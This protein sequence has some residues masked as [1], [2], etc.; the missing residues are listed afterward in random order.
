MAARAVIF[1]HIAERETLYDANQ[2]D[3]FDRRRRAFFKACL[4]CP[5]VG[6]VFVYSS[7]G[8][9]Y[10]VKA[11]VNDPSPS[12]PLYVLDGEQRIYDAL[13]IVIDR[14]AE[15][16]SPG[17]AES[18][19]STGPKFV[20]IG[21]RELASHL[22]R[23]QRV[24]PELVRS[25]ATRDGTFT[26]DSPKYVEAI[27]RLVRPNDPVVRVDIDVEVNPA[28]IQRILDEAE[29][30]A[31]N[32]PSSYWWFSGCY[33][34]SQSADPV[35]VFAVRQH[36]LVR[37]EERGRR[38]GRHYTLPKA[39]ES[40]L[41]DLAEIGATQMASDPKDQ[42]ADDDRLSAAAR[43]VIAKRGGISKH[44]GT[45]QVI[46]GA[47]L[48]ASHHA[49]WRLPPF[50]NAPEMVVWIDDH[51]K[52]LLHEAIGDIPRSSIER[53]PGA[54]MKQQRFPNGISVADINRST[55]Y[56]RRLLNGCLMEA[57]IWDAVEQGPGPLAKAVRT[58]VELG[59]VEERS[60][61]KDVA[62]AV[63]ARFD[64]VMQIWRNA[65]YGN[66]RLAT[67]ARLLTDPDPIM[68]AV[69]DAAVAY[70]EL[71]RLWPQHVMTI[72]GMVPQDF[73]W[74]FSRPHDPPPPVVPP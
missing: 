18:L 37:P 67:W 45:P 21:V 47:G 33:A 39:A 10:F 6:I 36:W 61:Q 70:V 24:N 11:L 50:M 28:A 69:V 64:D 8:I 35:N 41:V 54:A 30:C 66:D 42:P 4:Q 20:F 7:F 26:Y 29:R 2:L 14:A 65:D 15:E 16:L 9:E 71:C 57:A 48:V 72:T 74:A 5:N 27:L 52:R 56:F 32:V 22:L 73:Y 62:E 53:V 60:L 43:A 31:L 63:S 17:R 68:S 1:T 51:L 58:T 38:A 46:S 12:I 49:I 55:D 40:F 13:H 19:K 44:R 3:A 59:A 25:L 23:L 34:G